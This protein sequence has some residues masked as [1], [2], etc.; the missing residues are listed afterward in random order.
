MHAKNSI[1][2]LLLAILPIGYC[3]LASLAAAAGKKYFGTATDNPELSDNA[4]V[5]QLGNTNDFHQI[6]PVSPLFVLISMVTGRFSQG[7]S[8]KWVRYAIPLTIQSIV[9]N[10]G[11]RMPLNLPEGLSPFPRATRSLI[12]HRVTASSSEVL[13]WISY[14]ILIHRSRLD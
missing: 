5:A 8:M 4:Y 9:C 6:T 13:L 10:L 2:I 14:F 7:N 1:S 12:S 11:S 3:Q